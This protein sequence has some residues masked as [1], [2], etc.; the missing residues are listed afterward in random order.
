MVALLGWRYRYMW[1]YGCCT[2]LAVFCTGL[3]LLVELAWL[4]FGAGFG[5]VHPD[6]GVCGGFRPFL[7]LW[8]W[9]N[10]H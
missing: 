3:V 6:M 2:G 9:T 1:G 10:S 8:F 7:A 4:G 5:Q